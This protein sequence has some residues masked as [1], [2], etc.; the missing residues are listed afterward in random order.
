[1]VA[2]AISSTHNTSSTSTPVSISVGGDMQAGLVDGKVQ[3]VDV[4]HIDDDNLMGI[5]VPDDT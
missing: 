5:R 3:N 2:A 1:M 4:G